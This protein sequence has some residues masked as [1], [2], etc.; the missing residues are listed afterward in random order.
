MPIQ[1]LLIRARD[2]RLAALARRSRQA[3]PAA[4]ADNIFR[5]LA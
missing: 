5:F 1:S 3:G 4:T 2:N